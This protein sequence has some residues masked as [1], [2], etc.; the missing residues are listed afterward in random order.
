MGI[1]DEG[2]REGKGRRGGRKRVE[3]RT[4][5][6]RHQMPVDLPP[7]KT[8]AKTYKSV[9]APRTPSA[10]G[11]EEGREGSRGIEDSRQARTEGARRRLGRARCRGR[12][13]R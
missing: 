9:S 1:F 3:L 7:A 10:A 12:S 4:A 11:R 5:H 6:Q 8:D 2:R 13:R